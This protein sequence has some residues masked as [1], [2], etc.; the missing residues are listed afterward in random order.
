[1]KETILFTERQ[2][3]R[4]LWLILLLILL[5]GGF[6]YECIRQIIMDQQSGHPTMTNTSLITATA[7]VIMVTL[8]IFLCRLETRIQ[9]DGIY[10]RFFPFHFT[11]RFFPWNDLSAYYIR[12][13]NPI[14]EYG[15]WGLRG[16]GKNKALN[17]SGNK[18]LQLEIKN[19]SK[20]LIG[21]QKPEEL[22]AI[23]EQSAT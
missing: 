17:I 1:M 16:F 15:G 21:T 5:N 9:T 8:L 3:F 19:G 11:Y 14:P 20:L 6:L 7:I 13:Y 10:V 18:G 22:S 12:Q 2:Q 23:L 4:Q